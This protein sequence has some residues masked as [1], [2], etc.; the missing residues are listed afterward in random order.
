MIARTAAMPVRYFSFILSY[1]DELRLPRRP[2]MRAA[3]LTSAQIEVPD[4]LLPLSRFNALVQAV[5]VATG[6]T[7]LGFELGQRVTYD[8]HDKLGDALAHGRDLDEALRL[9]SRYFSSITPSYLMEYH[10]GPRLASVCFRPT[11]AMPHD[12]LA[13]LSETHALSFHRLGLRATPH[14]IPPYE[15]RM[16]IPRPAHAARYR[17]LAPA[18]VRFEPGAL[19]EVRIEVPSEFMDSAFTS[20]DPQRVTARQAQLNRA[21]QVALDTD[22]YGDWLKMLMLRAEG[23]QLK[24]ADA[25]SALQLTPHTLARRLAAE[26]IEFRELSNEVRM[27]RAAEMLAA[28]DL[29]IATVAA[30]L[31]YAHTS[32]FSGAF[33]A[34]NGVSPRQYRQSH[35]DR[36]LERHRRSRSR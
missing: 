19:P 28:S 2:L 16:P 9:C 14:R 20:H 15:L 8:L 24:L 35:K 13:V 29:P 36:G 3:G 23:R 6:R 17:Q 5:N 7:D 30:R 11:V 4:A 27:R 18:R 31:G 26:G 25:A 12:T 22:S 32:N 1:M 10:R 21:R 34:R 33:R